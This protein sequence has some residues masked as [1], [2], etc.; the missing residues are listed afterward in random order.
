LEHPAKSG[1]TDFR[2]VLARFI[3]PV[4]L[5]RIVTTNWQP[6]IRRNANRF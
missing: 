6:A 5:V 2:A 1:R 3:Q 4:R